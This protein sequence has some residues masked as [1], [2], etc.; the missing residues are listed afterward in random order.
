MTT[1]ITPAPDGRFIVYA[2]QSGKPRLDV[3]FDG[4]SVWLT[5]AQL[6]DL[7]GVSIPN[8]NMH[9]KN[10]LLEGELPVRPTIQNFL[11]VRQEGSRSVSREV[12]HYNLDMIICVGYRVKSQV[13]THFRIWAT[14]V[15]REFITKGF[16]LDDDRLK[17]PGGIDYFEELSRRIRAIRA[18]E[19]R[20]YQKVKDLFRDTSVDYDGSSEVAKVFFATIQNKLLYAV[21]GHTAA[22]LILDR[23]RSESTNC[24]LTTWS[25]DRPNKVDAVIAKNYLTDSELTVLDRLVEQFLAFAEGQAE[26]HLVTS[27]TEW[28]ASVD[29][30][31]DANRYSLLGGL[32]SVA[33]TDME[34]E[35]D[36]QWSVFSQSRRQRDREQAMEIEA[37]DLDD[38]YQ[39]HLQIEKKGSS[40]GCAQPD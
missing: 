5:Q 16:A 23:C 1:D 13:A 25:G 2:D 7:F 8:I 10:I 6:A 31:L 19:K 24:G 29:R 27:M 36:V 40:E 34:A 3:R 12:A 9:I 32:G 26:R 4:E 33:H 30:L 39:A 18:S 22:E 11:I 14:Q 20:F 15:L 38:L 21:T 28:V 17:T 37:E 35:V